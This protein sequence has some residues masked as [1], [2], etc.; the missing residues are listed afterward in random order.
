MVNTMKQWRQTGRLDV[1]LMVM[2]FSLFDISLLAFRLHWSGE[3]T[4]VFMVWNLIL[5]LI[6][7]LTGLVIQARSSDAS[8]WGSLLLLGLWIMFLPNASYMLT[9][10]GHLSGVYSKLMWFD[11]IMLSSFALTGLLIT[12]LSVF[13]IHQWLRGFLSTRV[14][15]LVV[16]SILYACGLGV[17]VGRFLRW[18]SWD[19]LSRPGAMLLEGAEH[20]VS[21]PNVLWPIGYVMLLGTFL[22]L[23]YKSAHFL[24]HQF[25]TR[26]RMAQLREANEV[27]F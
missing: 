22:L 24:F 14:S 4:Y 15:W 10:I 13:D 27:I 25:S 17:Y 3:L 5:A 21:G 20:F 18:N 2:A 9:D 23:L 8:R 1:L 6:P 11:L 12:L 19:V 16:V 26:L 7:Y